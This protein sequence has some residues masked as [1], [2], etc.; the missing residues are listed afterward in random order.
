MQLE[1]I[2]NINP[3][4]FV[5]NHFSNSK[6]FAKVTQALIKPNYP[7]IKYEAINKSGITNRNL[8]TANEGD[9]ILCLMNTKIRL[10][11]IVDRFCIVPN[12]FCVLRP[13][14][15]ST[16]ALYALLKMNFIQ[17]QLNS[18]KKSITIKDV[19]EVM[20]PYEISPAHDVVL[21]SISKKFQNALINRTSFQNIIDN[22]F[23]ELK[24]TLPLAL[25]D[26]VDFYEINKVQDTNNIGIKDLPFQEIMIQSAEAKDDCAT[27]LL[28]R[29]LK[30]IHDL[31]VGVICDNTDSIKANQ[32]LIKLKATTETLEA[33]G[34]DK[35]DFN[36]IIIAKYLSYYFLSSVGKKQLIQCLERKENH[37][38][39]TLKIS[40][41]K[42]LYVP[43]ALNI[44]YLVESIETQI[45]WH[46]AERYSSQLD[47]TTSLFNTFDKIMDSLVSENQHTHYVPKN[48]FTKREF[49]F[50]LAQYIIN[51]PLFSKL[52]ISVVLESMV[53]YG[54]F[55]SHQQSSWNDVPIEFYSPHHEIE[56][57]IIIVIKLFE[58]PLRLP[59]NAKKIYLK[60]Q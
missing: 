7:Y 11:G 42:E 58:Q 12:T 54:L 53:H 50:L 37:S 8:Y 18:A 60:E 9:I 33:I 31:K 55:E 23:N 41:L 20:F 15:I 30:N 48:L 44:R 45:Y 29:K 39:K 16:N 57:D 26:L 6:K 36:N 49:G 13:I 1:T 47:D 17:S 19:K 10:I 35:N 51:K 59:E 4:R 2:V 27:I 28:T 40:R 43:I 3:D 38:F 22:E 34:L 5:P 25:K 56:G 32:N 46:D 52:N 14:L 24:Y 21:K